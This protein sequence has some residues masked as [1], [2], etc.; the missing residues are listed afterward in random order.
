MTHLA[1]GQSIASSS[2][3]YPAGVSGASLE[4][5]LSSSSGQTGTKTIYWITNWDEVDYFKIT[6]HY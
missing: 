4:P 6:F 3:R 5:P 1:T 2:V